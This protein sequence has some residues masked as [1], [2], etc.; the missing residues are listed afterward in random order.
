MRIR[1]RVAIATALLGVVT[2]CSNEVDRLAAERTGGDP[3]KGAQAIRW[4]GCDSCHLIPGIPSANA[5]V[6]P[7]LIAM[8]RRSF[9]GGQLPNTPANMQQ[10]IQQPQAINPHTA[11]PNVGVT[12]LD[13][14]DIAAYLYTL[15]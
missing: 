12:D 7:P 1:C 15:R 9:V 11:M 10:W 8:S 2:A 6:G 3:T 5:L 14:R 4:Y 13:A